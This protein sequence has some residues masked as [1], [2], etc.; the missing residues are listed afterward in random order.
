MNFKSKNLI[1]LKTQN[2]EI[3]KLRKKLHKIKSFSFKVS[4]P[5]KLKTWMLRQ[6]KIIN[7]Y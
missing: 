3:S 7:I 1:M 6:S 2:N 4:K 5:V